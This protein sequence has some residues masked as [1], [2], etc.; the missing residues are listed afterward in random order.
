MYHEPYLFDDIA[1]PS[2]KY[3]IRKFSPS[4]LHALNRIKIK[5]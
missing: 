3:N 5:P 2:Y 4:K 1:T